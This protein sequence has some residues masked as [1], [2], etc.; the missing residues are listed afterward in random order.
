MYLCTNKNGC[1]CKLGAPIA[2]NHV[3][4]IVDGQFAELPS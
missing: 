1:R 2:R 3:L 4:D